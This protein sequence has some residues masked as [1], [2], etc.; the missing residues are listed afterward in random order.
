MALSDFQFV[1][2]EWQ[3]VIASIDSSYKN[4]KRNKCRKNVKEIELTVT[5]T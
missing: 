4:V 3:L 5:T 1:N 2:K